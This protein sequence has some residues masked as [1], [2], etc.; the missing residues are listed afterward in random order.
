MNDWFEILK[1]SLPSLF[2]LLGVLGMLYYF[3][4]RDLDK[5]KLDLLIGN[6]KLLT[7]IRLQ[8]YERISLLL[9]RIHPQIL[10]Q[11]VKN[12]KVNSGQMKALLIDSIK[13]EYDHNISQQIYVSSNLWG[14][15]TNSKEQIIR[16]VNLTSSEVNPKDNSFV[17][18]KLFLEKYNE[19]DTQPIETSREIL[20]REVRQYFS[21]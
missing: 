20:K 16:T 19:L 11:R 21:I 4:K 14:A 12:P 2:F 8:S 5:T 7:P 10:I 6:Q 9:E 1:Y 15:V 3:S 18:L 17:F 13:N